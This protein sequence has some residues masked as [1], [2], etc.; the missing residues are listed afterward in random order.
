MQRL[1][2]KAHAQFDELWTDE[3]ARAD[4]ERARRAEV[5]SAKKAGQLIPPKGAA[6]GT[7]KAYTQQAAITV[8]K[9][10]ADNAARLADEMARVVGYEERL[11]DTMRARDQT[12]IAMRQQLAQER[13]Q[14]ASKEQRRIYDCNR[15]APAPQIAPPRARHTAMIPKLRRRP[16]QPRRSRNGSPPFPG[17][18][19]SPHRHCHRRRPAADRRRQSQ[20]CAA[21]RRSAADHRPNKDAADRRRYRRKSRSDRRNQCTCAAA[22]PHH[23]CRQSRSAGTDRSA[24]ALDRRHRARSQRAHGASHAGA[25]ARDRRVERISLSRTTPAATI[26]PA[27]PAWQ[28]LGI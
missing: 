21:D 17:R 3:A 16:S 1:A 5:S 9:Q 28:A 14:F 23:A 6:D 8:S 4:A 25:E 26:P 13:A 11:A 12:T 15:S 7:G 18:N 2:A 20:R 27:Y 19:P 10:S 24:K 22:D